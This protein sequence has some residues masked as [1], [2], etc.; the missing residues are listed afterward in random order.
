MGELEGRV[1]FIDYRV[2]CGGVGLFNI[3]LQLFYLMSTHV[4]QCG[5]DGRGLFV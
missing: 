2:Q 1:G 4:P 3:L 5:I